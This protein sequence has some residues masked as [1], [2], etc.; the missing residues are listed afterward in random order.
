MKINKFYSGAEHIARAIARGSNDAHTHETFED[1]VANA[2]MQLED[3]PNKECVI[4]VKIIAIV[5]R[6]E[7]PIVVERLK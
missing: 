3:Q 6:K 5:K 1:A 7:Q 4:I 2:R